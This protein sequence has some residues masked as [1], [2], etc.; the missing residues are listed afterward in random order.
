[1]QRRHVI[2]GLV[3]LA[4]VLGPGLSSSASR[5]GVAENS[6]APDIFVSIRA[7]RSHT[8]GTDYKCVTD[9]T[10]QGYQ[11]ALCQA[12]CSYPDSVAPSPYSPPAQVRPHG[13]DFQCVNSCTQQGYQ[14]AFCHAKCSY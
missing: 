14:Y 4:V 12:R 9:C 8:L 13:T 10:S 3:F 2:L 5:S 1:M 7:A 11:Y 6:P